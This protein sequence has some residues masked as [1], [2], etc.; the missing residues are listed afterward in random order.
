MEALRASDRLLVVEQ[1]N[2]HAKAEKQ[3]ELNEQALSTF[4]AK[5][6]I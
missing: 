1:D 5:H 4:T 2:W 6:K 3:S